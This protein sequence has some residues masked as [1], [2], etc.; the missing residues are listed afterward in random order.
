M[1]ASLNPLQALILG[2]GLVLGFGSTLS[3]QQSGPDARI[4]ILDASGTMA[5]N[6]YPNSEGTRWQEAI[7]LAEEYFDRLERTGD[8][9]P[10]EVLIFGETTDYLATAEA[11]SRKPA[12]QRTFTNSRNDPADGAR[13]R[14]IEF[15][16]SG[17]APPSMTT[18]STIETYV[19]A[20]PGR[21]T[22]GGMTPQGRT[23]AN[24]F[25]Q[26][27]IL[28]IGLVAVPKCAFWR[29]RVRIFG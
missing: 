6:T 21:E 14:D 25:Y 16:T 11:E 28:F 18:Y 5:I 22:Q 8:V 15:V 19:D 3:A 12:S 29:S 23:S 26:I 10:T 7:G 24:K 17:F 4:V 1:I 20:L 9:V 13:C 27:L 2:V